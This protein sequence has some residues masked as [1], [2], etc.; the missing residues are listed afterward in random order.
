MKV[1]CKQS[2]CSRFITFSHVIARDRAMIHARDLRSRSWKMVPY[3]FVPVDVWNNLLRY[4]WHFRF[5][6]ILTILNSMQYAHALW[7]C[8][9]NSKF[10]KGDHG[11]R[12]HLD[13]WANAKKLQCLYENLMSNNFRITDIP[14]KNMNCKLK[15]H[16]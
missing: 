11:F 6:S 2:H 15:L 7:Q 10:F 9:S 3:Q 4:A 14:K 16:S 1:I 12:R 13:K 8:C 5:C